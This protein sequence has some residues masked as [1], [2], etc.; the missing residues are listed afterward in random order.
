MPI[1][2][3]ASLRRTSAMGEEE[4]AAASVVLAVTGATGVM[5]VVIGWITGVPTPIAVPT[6]IL[7]VLMARHATVA[8]AWAAGAAW[9]FVLPLASGAGLLAPAMM[10]AVSATLAVGPERVAEVLFEREPAPRADAASPD[11]PAG[12]IEEA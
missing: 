4:L 5:I 1:G 7:L 9:L 8:A 3:L 11:E 6:A 10:A 12:W 2:W